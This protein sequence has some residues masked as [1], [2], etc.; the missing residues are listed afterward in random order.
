MRDRA[1]LVILSDLIR[2]DMVTHSV[3]SKPA[4]IPS[5]RVIKRHENGRAALRRRYE[6]K[7]RLDAINRASE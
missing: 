6:L 1:D 4:R 2:I 3:I 7:I 5:E